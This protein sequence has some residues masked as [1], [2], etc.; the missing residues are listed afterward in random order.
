MGMRISRVPAMTT[1]QLL[2][3]TIVFELVWAFW[4]GPWIVDRLSRAE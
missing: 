3:L 4:I 2:A 1:N